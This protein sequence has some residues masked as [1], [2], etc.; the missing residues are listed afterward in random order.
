MHTSPAD[1]AYQP[2]PLSQAQAVAWLWLWDQEKDGKQVLRV[3]TESRATAVGT[4]GSSGRPRPGRGRRL[5]PS[6]SPLVHAT[7]KCMPFTLQREY[8]NESRDQIKAAL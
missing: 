2:S 5:V 6:N 8:G 3:T 1:P 7:A 4:P